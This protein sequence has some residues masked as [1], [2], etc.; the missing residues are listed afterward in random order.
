MVN[1]DTLTVECPR[2]GE[3]CQSRAFLLELYDNLAQVDAC[4]ILNEAGHSRLHRLLL[5]TEYPESEQAANLR[6]QIKT[7]FNNESLVCAETICGTMANFVV[8]VA[9]ND[10][11]T[12]TTTL[13]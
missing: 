2:T 7:A 6:S 12:F 9:S 11:F 8:T 1:P 5:K 10:E 3:P 13:K 4:Q